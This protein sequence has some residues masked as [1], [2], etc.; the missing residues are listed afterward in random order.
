M[1]HR[2]ILTPFA[3]S[4]SESISIC[5]SSSENLWIEMSYHNDKLFTKII[6]KTITKNNDSL[7]LRIIL[8]FALLLPISLFFT[9]CFLH[10]VKLGNYL[11]CMLSPL[12]TLLFYFLLMFWIHISP[13]AKLNSNHSAEHMII[14]FI[15]EKQRLPVTL[16]ELRKSSRFHI[17]CGS[18]ED[19]IDFVCSFPI[20]KFLF[21][22]VIFIYLI[23]FLS[24][25]ISIII[26]LL[27]IVILHIKKDRIILKPGT[28]IYIKLN[29][30]CQ[31]FSTTKKVTDKSLILAYHIAKKYIEYEYPEYL[32]EDWMQ[33]NKEFDVAKKEEDKDN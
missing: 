15:T 33:T 21:L 25:Y 2:E 17:A 22:L 4:T 20:T 13:S 16:C 12:L 3:A 31:L 14:N 18:L 6:Q 5:L 8:S 19:Y 9:S 11:L 1:N 29:F 28:F 27:L 23:T 30:F 24:M 32:Q 10:F 26:I 7:A